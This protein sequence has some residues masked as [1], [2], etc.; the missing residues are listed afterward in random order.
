MKTVA[1]VGGGITGITALYELHRLATKNKEAIHIILIEKNEYLGG[2]IHSEHEGSFIME[3][4]ADSIVARHEA[5][6][7]LVKALGLEDELVYNETG[8]SYIYTH[9]Q[10]HP[11][12][13]DAVFGIPMS[14]ESLQAS[15]LISEA[16]KKAAL[17]DLT[18]PNTTFTKE[19]A[20]GDFLTYFLGE[21]LVQKQI[22]P[23]LSGVYSGDL[24][25]LSIASTLP[26]LIDYKNKYGS[27]IKGFEANK[28]QFAKTADKKFISFKHGLDTIA[29]RIESLVPEAVIKKSTTVQHIANCEGKYTL[30][31]SD[32]E[33]LADEL[34]LALPNAQIAKLLPVPALQTSFKKFTT[35]SVITMYVGFDIPDASLPADGTGYI[36]SHHADVVCN[37][38]TWTSRKWK[39]TSQNGNLLVRLFY[40][41][42]NE[43]YDE[44]Q[45]MTEDELAQIGLQDIQQSL[46]I[47]AQ[48]QIVRVTKWTNQMPRYDLAHREA[49]QQLE[50]QMAVYY[51]HVHLAGCSYYGVGIGACIA[52]GQQTAKHVFKQLF[53]IEQ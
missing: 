53:E 31:T 4:G 49:L 17:K 27:I 14:V 34:I 40:K 30:H 29:R 16:G 41:N 43:R 13:K 19:S 3:T 20:I 11:I 32:G 37:A 52:N 23:V 18:T 46:H 12:P 26:Y 39:H 15:T 7:P 22:A 9:N 21:E 28:A 35:A 33:L 25:E 8:I 48:P 36:V 38:A 44:L 5:V 1:I 10:L 42:T 51:P 24:H 2:K 47:D 50:Q 45:Q 6:L